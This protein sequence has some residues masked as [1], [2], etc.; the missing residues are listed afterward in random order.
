MDHVNQ[1]FHMLVSFVVSLQLVA[2]RLTA[3]PVKLRKF[4]VDHNDHFN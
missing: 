4:R 3:N 1:I 2:N